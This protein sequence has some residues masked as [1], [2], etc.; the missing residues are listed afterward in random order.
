[1]FM[2]IALKIKVNCLN[3]LISFTVMWILTGCVVD[4]EKSDN[5]LWLDED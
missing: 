1:M 5:G 4:M 3:C 2:K